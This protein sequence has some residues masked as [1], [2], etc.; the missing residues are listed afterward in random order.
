MK[1][2]L[3]LQKMIGRLYNN[4]GKSDKEVFLNANKEKRR[5]K[6]VRR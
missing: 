1:V 4:I 3:T 5:D 2:K 6:N